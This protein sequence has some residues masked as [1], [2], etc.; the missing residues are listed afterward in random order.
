MAKFV[1]DD[2]MN[3]ERRLPANFGP[4]KGADG[5]A[6]ITGPCGDTMEF[7]LRA[8]ADRIVQVMFT[9]DG[10]GSSIACGSTAAQLAEGADI[11]SVCSLS[12]DDVL[13]A[14]S[15]AMLPEEDRHCALLAV[16]TIKAAV[17]DYLSQVEN[18][19]SEEASEGQQC[20]RH[21]GQAG[22]SRGTTG[23]PENSGQG[24]GTC[25][26]EKCSARQARPGESQQDFEERQTLEHRL[27]RIAHKVIVLS[28][29]GGVGKSTV[30]VNLAISLALAGRRVGLLD[31]DIHGPS[32]P[33]MLRLEGTPLRVTADQVTLPVKVGDMK[34]MSIGFFLQHQ[35]EAVI[36]RGP[37]KM[38]VI[39]QFLRD[40]EWG[41][42]D[43]LVIDSP[44][45]TGDELLSICQMIEDIDG[46]VA[47]TTPQEVATADVRKSINFCRQLSIPLFGVVENMSGFACPRCGEVI[48][49]FKTGG[50]ERMSRLMN[51]PFLGR[52]PID[53]AIAEACDAGTPYI[54]HYAQTETARAFEHIILPILRLSTPAKQRSTSSEHKSEEERAVNADTPGK[55]EP[56]I[57]MN[58][59]ERTM[60]MNPQTNINRQISICQERKPPCV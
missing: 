33:K 17:A 55:E 53:P 23:Q 24:C 47:V 5:H 29:K 16:N 8:D 4:L 48:Q 59:Q 3:G 43:Y 27:C 20:G 6:I 32:V 19:E 56:A 54:H 41:D 31:I 51:I 50:G 46:A 22:G 13:Q 7:W 45:G 21:E 49:I 11:E 30:A 38:G 26:S 2:L 34:V 15:P 57:D 14:L 1:S 44:P 58:P 36:W 9:T 60:N 28:G 37:L 10:C 42:L 18:L 52:I 35:D 40:V 39:R 12:Q 25:E